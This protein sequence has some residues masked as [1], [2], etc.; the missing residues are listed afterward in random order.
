MSNVEIFRPRASLAQAGIG[1]LLCV[2]FLW[3]GAY[4]HSLTSE[5]VNL[6]IALSIVITLYM[7]LVR[8]KII[9]SDEGMIITNP[10][11]EFSIGWSDV[12][13]I[14]NRW[15]LTIQTSGFTVQAWAATAS[16]RRRRSIHESEIRGLDIDLGGSMRV[17][18]SPFANSGAAAYR[19][20]ARLRRFQES[21]A[22]Q[23][24][25]TF[26]RARHQLWVCALAILATAIV[27]NSVGH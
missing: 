26:K 9:F 7:Y 23:P 21:G 24:L 2:L 12:I 5:I 3:S 15:A 20:R 8:P 17:A 1:A 4:E 10:V 19:A 16:G 6:L 14:D 27:V 22:I 11:S 25:P 18:D 13:S